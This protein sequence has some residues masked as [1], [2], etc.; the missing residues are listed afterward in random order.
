MLP[1]VVLAALGILRPRWMAV[2]FGLVVVG[3]VAPRLSSVSSQ[4]NIFNFDL[5]S[6]ASGNAASWN[7]PQQEFS[8]TVARCLAL[9]LWG[10]ALIS[11]WI[12]RGRLGRVLVPGL[13]AFLPILTL[14]GG[15]YGGEA[16]Y[17][18]FAFSL[19][20]TALLIG[21]LWVGRGRKGVP[22]TVASAVALLAILLGGLQGLHGQ[23]IVH[24]VSRTDIKA[25]E[26]FYANAEPGSALVLV[27]PNFPTKLSADYGS[28]NRGHVSVDIAL[29]GDPQFTGNLTGSRLIEVEQYIEAMRYSTNYLVVSSAMEAYTDYFGVEPQGWE[30]SLEQALRQSADWTVFY[31]DDGVTIFKL[32]G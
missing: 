25:A 7:T 26:Y 4:Y 21:G 3:F 6:N 17:R 14:A 10:V 29:V 30:A 13:L 9:G 12:N 22:L 20:F 11:L 27:A 32:I 19:P 15:N 5:L 31:Q 16:I 28:F 24:Q 8:A 1:I 2:V 18:V 23:L